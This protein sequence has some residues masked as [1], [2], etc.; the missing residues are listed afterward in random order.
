MIEVVSVIFC[1]SRCLTTM[2]FS[3]VAEVGSSTTV[4]THTLTGKK[5]L[6]SFSKREFTTKRNTF[7]LENRLAVTQTLDQDVLLRQNPLTAALKP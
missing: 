1:V 6:D 4:H 7:S 5:M 2:N 3:D